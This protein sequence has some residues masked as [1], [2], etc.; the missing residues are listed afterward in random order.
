MDLGLGVG[1]ADIVLVA[2]GVDLYL[3][4][5][6]VDLGFRC[7]RGGSFQTP[8][9]KCENLYITSATN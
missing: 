7:Q 3:D 2:G 9:L 6:G 4:V 5:G 8:K 1:G